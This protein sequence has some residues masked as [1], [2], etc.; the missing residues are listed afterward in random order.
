MGDRISRLVHTARHRASV[1][2]VVGLVVAGFGAVT[3]AWTTAWT[4]ARPTPVAAH[5]RVDAP[6]VGSVVVAPAGNMTATRLALASPAVT[7]HLVWQRLFPQ[8]TF[9]ESSP[10]LAQLGRP[11]V[12]VG[13]LDGKVYGFDLN[14]G[15]NLPGWPVRTAHPVNSSPAAADLFGTGRD[16][17]VVGSGS[18]DGSSCG[19]GGVLAIDPSGA[20]RWQHTGA[21]GSCANQAFHSSATI[22]DVTGSGVPD[23]TVG[24]LGLRSWSWDSAGNL[25][26]G[27]PYYTDDTVFA[28]AALADLNH[29][30]IPELI[31]G[32]DSSPGGQIDHRGG[33]VRAVSGDGRT[34]WQFFTDEMVRSSPAVG[35]LTGQGQPSIVFGTGNY[36]VNQPGGAKDAYKVFSLDAGGKLQWV[37]NL[38]A[39]TVGGPAL[40]DV[41]GNGQ[42]DTVIGTADGPRAGLVWVLGPDGKPLPHWGGVPSGGGVV[43][44]G[45]STADLNGDGAQDVLVPTGS[46]VF[47][48]DGR[49]AAPL[50][51]LDASEVGFQSTPLVTTDPDGSLGIT[52]AGTTGYGE[53]V[54]QHWAIPAAAGASLGTRGWPTFHHDDRRTGNAVTPPLTNR[55]CQGKG[56]SGYWEAASDGGVFGWCGA[57]FHG[58]PTGARITSPIV[59]IASTPS[60][61]GYWEASADGGVFAYGDAPFLGSAVGANLHA[62]VVGIARTRSGRGYWLA[63]ADGGVFAFGDAPFFGGAGS[64]KLPFPI[65]AM[66]PTSSGGGY[67]L[68]GNQGT[69]L[70]YG[71][72]RFFGSPVNVALSSPI[73]G[74]APTPSGL[75]YWLVGSDGGVFTYGDA[76]YQGSTG[77]MNLNQPIVAMAATA[78]GRGYWLV[79]A[80]GGIFTYGDARYVGSAASM[81]L[82]GPVVAIAP[83]GG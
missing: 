42:L 46:G 37:R 59:S 44:G 55:A 53:G 1:V 7:P 80:D 33:L 15:S 73:V 62:P 78:A 51:S 34:L 61:H 54:V 4:T 77:A 69:V 20:V 71:D 16:E 45:I 75:G 36:W 32:G 48:Y 81:H 50:F 30:G 76:V 24:A 25:N 22:G 29:D 17:I 67:W 60:G 66:L 38:G 10:V 18:A 21:D 5:P 47:A 52:L 56:I 35:D 2:A 41:A 14:D 26:P 23:I 9:R 40:A 39:Q 13:A 8:V 11:S 27:W 68:V 82:G 43:I 64:V 83:R 49:T 74:G 28:T 79:A 31:M 72:A 58:A 63:S 3:T 65:V 57:G 70:T 19:G 6:S 12:V